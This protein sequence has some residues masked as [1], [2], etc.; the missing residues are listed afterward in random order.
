MGQYRWDKR[1]WTLT[2]SPPVHWVKTGFPLIRPPKTLS[3]MRYCSFSVYFSLDK[4][5]K[6][7]TDETCNN[8][9][10]HY[11]LDTVGRHYTSGLTPVQRLNDNCLLSLSRFWHPGNTVGILLFM[12]YS[13]GQT[14]LQKICLSFTLISDLTTSPRRLRSN[15]LSWPKHKSSTWGPRLCEYKYKVEV[16]YEDRDNGFLSLKWKDSGT[17]G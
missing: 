12:W 13:R 16:V 5:G 2:E 6:E 15:C 3:Q 8:T 14:G 17:K 10:L 4:R 1:T 9:L 11:A 7:E